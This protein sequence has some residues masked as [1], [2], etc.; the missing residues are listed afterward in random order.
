MLMGKPGRDRGS[1][2]AQDDLKALFLCF[3]NHVVKE[4][5]VILQTLF[6]MAQRGYTG[7]PGVYGE[8]WFREDKAT[9]T[10]PYVECAY[11]ASLYWK[12]R[13]EN[14]AGEKWVLDTESYGFTL[15]GWVSE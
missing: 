10:R 1:G 9:D 2:R 12:F 4:R 13:V 6:F 7:V 11:I 3:C 5:K 15:F 8:E 14:A